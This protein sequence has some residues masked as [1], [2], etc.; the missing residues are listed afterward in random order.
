MRSRHAVLAIFFVFIFLFGSITFVASVP[1]SAAPMFSAQN[2]KISI[3]NES[4]YNT[5]VIENI[6][7]GTGHIS[8]MKIPQ[9][10][11]GQIYVFEWDMPDFINILYQGY[12]ALLQVVSAQGESVL[13]TWYP[14]PN[15]IGVFDVRSYGNLSFAST[16]FYVLSLYIVPP[17]DNASVLYQ[18]ASFH[19]YPLAS[20]GLFNF[21]IPNYFYLYF[22]LGVL[23]ISL[24]VLGY[25]IL[26][27]KEIRKNALRYRKTNRKTKSISTRR[28]KH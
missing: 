26:H 6:T 25:S 17:G 2:L 27:A 11:K 1:V 28:R 16:S 19:L 10:Q 13:N 8:S 4:T 3:E 22:A 21:P 15:M 24:C 20:S 9:L 7:F 14:L 23:L 5:S 18:E 12:N